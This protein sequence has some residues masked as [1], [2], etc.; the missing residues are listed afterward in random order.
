MKKIL[1]I[2]VF[3]FSST[4]VFCQQYPE[5]PDE[6]NNAQVNNFEVPGTRISVNKPA[7]FKYI[8]ELSRLQKWR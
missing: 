2:F 8:P 4:T 3:L 5:I 6:I 1:L 7:H